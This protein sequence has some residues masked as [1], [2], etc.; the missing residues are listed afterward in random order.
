[1][2]G[3]AAAPDWTQWM[4]WDG[5]GDEQQPGTYQSDV[6]AS[7]DVTLTSTAFAKIH[8]SQAVSPSST[9]GSDL[10]PF[11]SILSIPKASSDGN[12]Q[13]NGLPTPSHSSSSP[14]TLHIPEPRLSGETLRSTSSSELSRLHLKRKSS[15]E[16]GP[17]P[18]IAATNDQQKPANKKRPHNVIEKRYRANLNDKI[19]ELRQSV[20][21]LRISA[22]KGIKDGEDVEHDAEDPSG[23]TKLNK[24]SILS[25]AV[26]YIRHLEIRNKRLDDENVALK[27][28]LL[29]LERVLASDGNNGDER[30]VAFTSKSS[31]EVVDQETGKCSDQTRRATEHPPQGLIPVPESM[32]K[33]RQNQP[34]EH[35]GAIYDAPQE[36]HKGGRRWPAK[37]MIGSLAGLM[38]VDG[39]SESQD[40]SD[41]K[42]KGL[43]GIPLE[44]MDGWWF[45][46]SP[47][48][49]IAAFMQYCRAGGVIPLIKGFLALSLLALIVFTYLFNSKPAEAEQAERPSKLRKVPSLASPIEVRRQAWLTS[50][51]TLGLPHHSFFPEWF[52]VTIEWLKYT[53]RLVV[54][55][56]TY[57]WITGRIEEDELARVKAWDIAVDAQLAGGD[58]EISRSRLVLSIFASG[59]LPQT[60]TRLML[61]ALHC[62]VVLWRVGQD[63]GVVSRT[64][65]K[66]A[67]F[68]A[69][70]QWRRAQRLAADT[71]VKDENALPTHLAELLSL[72]CGDVMLDAVLQRAYNLMYDRS[73]DEVSHGSNS[74][75]DVVVE[76]HAIRSPLDAIAAWWSCQKLHQALILSLSDDE[77]DQALFKSTLDL[78][79]TIAPPLSAAHTRALAVKAVFIEQ[80]RASNAQKVLS[81]L[82]RSSPTTSHR[83]TSGNPLP[84]FIDSSMPLSACS[85]VATVLDCA[86]IMIAL[87]NRC[88]TT[89]S[90][91]RECTVVGLFAVLHIDPEKTSLLSFA[92]AYHVLLQ[93]LRNDDPGSGVRWLAQ[94]ARNLAVWARAHPGSTATESSSAG[95]VRRLDLL[96]NEL[97]AGQA[98]EVEHVRVH[99]YTRGHGPTRRYSSVSND[100]GYGSLGD[101]EVDGTS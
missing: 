65:N 21:S 2:E 87:R 85:E 43:F 101:A 12:P 56:Q 48:A 62:R 78:A 41:S 19:A 34:Q 81:A 4:Q 93:S 58:P 47:K 82:P 71:N 5:D 15:H 97:E 24:A 50:I 61:K 33:L 7:T 35:Y 64:S 75:M 94:T 86:S 26:E 68:L 27:Q 96:C 83:S 11:L 36:G 39:L 20:P 14:E 16:Q 31:V 13:S 95:I 49:F 29:K 67:V 76:D 84:V 17:V 30:A 37:F 98:H 38:I 57:A 23:S 9:A 91:S 8:P 42:A 25:K 90:A 74:L 69:H 18:S 89:A 40:G 44:F 52:A 22:T 80:D 53:V 45:L 92:P 99:R 63:G 79:L 54:G 59:T 66:I 28:R 6:S 60:P 51:Q 73:I 77:K 10:Q 70:R 72:D 55:F 1:M 3:I 32:K 88:T 46:R 100:T